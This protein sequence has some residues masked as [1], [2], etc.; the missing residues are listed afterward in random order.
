MGET[1]KKIFLTALLASATLGSLM[2]KDIFVS[3]STGKNKNAGT[4]E[5]P[6]KNL[7]KALAVAQDNDVIHIAEGNYPGRMKCGWFKIEKPVSLFGGY[8]SDFTQRDPL[9]FK[10]MFQPQN[11]NNDKKSGALGLLHIELDKSPMTAPKG[12][13]MVIDG[14]IFDD[15]FASSYHATKGKPDGFD[16]GMW[17]EGPAYNKTADKFPSANRYSIYTATASRGDGTLTIRNCTFVNGSNYAVNINWYKG[18]VAVINNV[19]CNNRMLSINV[20]CSNGSGKIDWECANNTILFTWSRLN[21]LADMGFAIRNNTNCNADIH[22][23]IIGLNVLTG[24]D[25]TKG[26]PKQK[27]TKLDNNIFF[28]N[29]ESDVQMTVSPSIAKVKVDGFEDLEGVD[30]IESIE[31]NIDL[32]DPS[33]F[34][35][36]INARYLNAFLS[37]KY[38]EKTKLDPGKCNALRSVLGLPLQGTITTTCDMYANRYPWEEALNLFGAVKDYGAQMPQ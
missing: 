10:T 14:I 19:F 30:G 23:N 25:N 20:T 24:F 34:K 2:A 5:A 11:E 26:N 36:R 37:M 22:N 33:I 4:K 18:K 15:G 17:L 38:S 8:S 9:K 31:G 29:R 35:G 27:T 28:L 32:K 1:M 12:F 3:L 7:W 21:D 13:H 6:Y 16:T